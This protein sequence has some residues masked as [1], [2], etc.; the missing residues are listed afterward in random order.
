MNVL[1]AL[2]FHKE[3]T[4]LGL[5][6]AKDWNVNICQSPE[7]YRADIFPK[8]FKE[9]VLQPAYEKH[10]QWIEPQDQLNRATNGFKSML[11]FIINN[12]GTE[13]WSRFVKE[14]ADLDRVRNENFWDT[15]PEYNELK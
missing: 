12:D 4:D 1:H 6:K 7:W 10:I 13:H 9:R 14:V 8:E 5:I 3:W 2:D 11:S 15:F